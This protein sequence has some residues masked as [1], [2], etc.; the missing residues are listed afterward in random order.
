[1]EVNI[2]FE[3][4]YFKMILY[5]SVLQPPQSVSITSIVIGFF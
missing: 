5:I 1:M 3:K 4:F 2:F